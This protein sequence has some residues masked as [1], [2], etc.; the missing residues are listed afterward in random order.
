MPDAGTSTSASSRAMGTKRAAA[1][2]VTKVGTNTKIDIRKCSPESGDK[3]FIPK[4]MPNSERYTNDKEHHK[5]YTSANRWNAVVALQRW[6]RKRWDCFYASRVQGILRILQMEQNGTLL[7]PE[8][9]VDA[10]EMSMNYWLDVWFT[11]LDC[12]LNAAE[13]YDY[14][15][16][17]ENQVRFHMIQELEKIDPQ[18]SRDM[19]EDERRRIREA[20]PALRVL[21]VAP[22]D[23]LQKE[24]LHKVMPY[25]SNAL[26]DLQRTGTERSCSATGENNYNTPEPENVEKVLYEMKEQ[27]L[28]ALKKKNAEW[29]MRWLHSCDN[30]MQMT[31][32]RW[33]SDRNGARNHCVGI[34][35]FECY[36]TNQKPFTL[37]LQILSCIFCP[38]CKGECVSMAVEM[39]RRQTKEEMLSVAPALHDVNCKDDVEVRLELPPILPFSSSIPDTVLHSSEKEKMAPNGLPDIYVDPSDGSCEFRTLLD[40]PPLMSI[41]GAHKERNSRKTSE[42][43]PHSP[44]S[45]DVK[46]PNLESSVPPPLEVLAES[47]GN[48]NQGIVVPPERLTR[49]RSQSQS[50]SIEEFLENSEDDSDEVGEE[51]NMCSDDADERAC[52]NLNKKYF[53]AREQRHK[54]IFFEVEKRMQF[55]PSRTEDTAQKSVNGLGICSG[56]QETENDMEGFRGLENDLQLLGF[57]TV[58]VASDLLRNS[59]GVFANSGHLHNV[60]LSSRCFSSPLYC[61]ICEL[62][63]VLLPSTVVRECAGTAETTFLEGINVEN[64][65][66]LPKIQEEMDL[67]HGCRRPVHI[68]CGIRDTN[69]SLKE[70]EDVNNFLYCCLACLSQ[71]KEGKA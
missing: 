39:R 65:S 68:D 30:G 18:W 6:C 46:P 41:G 57:R 33:G 67:C 11:F 42:Q 4:A 28:I 38:K 7:F 23:L 5:F 8:V 2:T 16:R 56:E 26:S 71:K 69:I 51:I 21:Y 58:N 54:D 20:S 62:E 3:F 45:F 59:G 14:S 27:L 53:S 52:D 10:K 63:G 61:A 19:S 43:C 13:L 64:S 70:E 66:E 22:H 25:I 35:P 44:T 9:Q 60:P 17:R 15:L 36:V 34:Y 29:L 48:A 31:S 40:A 1:F 32:S 47:D 24:V 12:L 37:V 55:R 49:Q 50:S